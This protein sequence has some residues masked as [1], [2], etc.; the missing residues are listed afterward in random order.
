MASMESLVEDIFR[1]A[2]LEPAGELSV[3]FVD[4]EEMSRLNSQYRNIDGPTDVLSFA[5]DEGQEVPRPDDS[6]FVPLLGD[7][8]ISIPTASR[9]ASERGHSLKR[10]LSLLLIHGI[11]HLFGY[12]HDNVYQQSFMQEEEKSILS[13]LE[14]M[15]PAGR[16]A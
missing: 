10:E 2:E 11:L 6:D 9:Q 13:A 7:V 3:T 16:E 15:E 4:D 12:D 1:V 5:M 8:I 14:N